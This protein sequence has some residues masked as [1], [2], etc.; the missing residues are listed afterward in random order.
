MES[1][2]KEL[3]TMKKTIFILPILILFLA[4]CHITPIPN[5]GFRMI[6]IRRDGDY[7]RV[8]RGSVTRGAWRFDDFGAVGNN[9]GFYEVAGSSGNFDVEGGRAPAT[10]YM[11]AI[12]DWD[13]CTGQATFKDVE[14]AQINRLTCLL[15]RIQFPLAPSLVYSNSTPVELQATLYGV[16]TNYGMPIFH[17]ENY[18]GQLIATT[19]ATYVNG[20]DV[21]ASSSCL[22]DKPVGTYTV[23]VYNALSPNSP[24]SEPLGIS[25]I[26]IR[27]QAQPPDDL[28]IEMEQQCNASGGIW[29]GCNRGCFSPI[30]IDIAGNG[31]DLT[32]GQN[33]VYFDLAGEGFKNKIS[34]TSANSD[35]AWLVLDR[36]GNGTIDSG[37]ELFG[38]YT[39]QPSSIP[40]EDRNGFLVL[41][42]Y[43]KA[44]EGG[45][46]DGIINRFDNVF[47]ALRLWQDKNHNGISEQSELFTL[48]ELDIK[49]M[50]LEFRTS[51]RT[52]EHGNRFRYR[53][54]V[55]DARNAS[56]GKWAWDIFLVRPQP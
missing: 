10:W 26:T 33:G 22:T 36:N 20:N 54:K 55:R 24:P 56:V 41:A 42:E 13:R 14:R 52:D 44:S 34:W 27:N 49:F 51:K 47:F 6:T 19:T 25:S 23:K 3:N 28:C 5:P 39:P 32:N 38:N 37:L 4:G 11:E 18:S 40:V 15:F 16:D 8:L 46:N 35:D 9:L 2:D 7:E 29:K 17:F 45:N 50:E 30:V 21:R 31:F 1:Q 43:D 53:A 48:P 12:A